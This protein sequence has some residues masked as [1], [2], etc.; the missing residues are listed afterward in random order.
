MEENQKEKINT[1]NKRLLTFLKL[2]L[3]PYGGQ[4]KNQNRMEI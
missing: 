2:L 4:E 1:L 3:D